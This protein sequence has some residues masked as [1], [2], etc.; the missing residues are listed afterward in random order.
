MLTAARCESCGFVCMWQTPL[1]GPGRESTW[2]SHL[3]CGSK[4]L[5]PP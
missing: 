2:L 1:A 3:L 5:L 4:A